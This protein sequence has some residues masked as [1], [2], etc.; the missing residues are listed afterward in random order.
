M[1]IS[2][3]IVA[4]NI[5]KPVIDVWS[6]ITE[7]AQMTQ[8]FFENIPDFNSEI[9]F[10]TE[11]DVISG[12]RTFRHQWKIIDVNPPNQIVYSWKYAEYPGEGIV[13]FE[14]IER[15]NDSQL[16]IIAE[17]MHSFPQHIAEFSRD[18]CLGGWN[19]FIDRLVNYLCD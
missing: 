18:S 17:G 16:T 6:A 12:E 7:H 14:L 10:T 5:E 11:F 13:Y 9:G 2:P 15:K 4:R 8:W 3:I 19:Y 1:D